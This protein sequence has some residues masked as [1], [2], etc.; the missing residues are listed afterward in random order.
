M[1]YINKLGLS[2]IFIII[3]HLVGLV[4]FLLPNYH[5]FFFAFVPFHLLLMGFILIAN[6]EEFSNKLVQ[7]ILVIA[8]IG[9]FI[10][11][12]GVA[13]GLIFGNY[14]YG[15]T[16]GYKLIDVPPIIGVNWLIL[17]FCV[18]SVIEKHLKFSRNLRSL[19]GAAVMVTIDFLIEPVAVKFD[20]WNWA[21]AFIPFQNYIAWFII[22]FLM[23]R[24]YYQIDFLKTN[25]VAF[26][27]LISQI[28]FFIVL[29][30]T[31]S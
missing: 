23:I 16:L 30:L 22:S 8:I 19:I 6:Q 20:Y 2:L 5:D 12:I 9:Y 11:V 31:M 15:Q 17:V 3:F 18:G 24:F 29:N 21:D 28:I 27:L 26:T 7:A 25:K 4:G 14:Q 13:S 1:K 10:E